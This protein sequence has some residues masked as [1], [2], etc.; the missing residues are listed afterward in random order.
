VCE[1]QTVGAP[2][3]TDVNLKTWTDR[4]LKLETLRKP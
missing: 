3:R 4:K 2:G 1:K